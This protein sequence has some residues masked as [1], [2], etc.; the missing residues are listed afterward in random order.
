MSFKPLFVCRNKY[1]PSFLVGADPWV[2]PGLTYLP[3]IFI[4]AL[5]LFVYRNRIQSVIPE[6]SIA[7]VEGEFLLREAQPLRVWRTPELSARALVF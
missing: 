5:N 2:L 1:N 4:S 3:Y 6:Y 7:D